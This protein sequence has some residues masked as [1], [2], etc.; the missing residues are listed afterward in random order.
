MSKLAPQ[1]RDK[2]PVIIASEHLKGVAHD[3]KNQLNEN[4][5]TFAVYFDLPEANHHL[6]EGL[7]FPKSNLHNL[8]FLFLESPHYHP[9]VLRRYPIT[10]EVVAKH[11]LPVFHLQT[12]GASP[13]QE[14]MDTIQSGAYLAYYLSQE[15]GID[16]GPI[17]WVNWFKDQLD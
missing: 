4:A 14:V 17:P 12:Q 9:E 10:A 6:L 3:L 13:L 15:Y 7:A 1:L 5:K 2:I 11:H 8:A 16:P